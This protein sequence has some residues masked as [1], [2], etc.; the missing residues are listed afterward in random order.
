MNFPQIIQKNLQIPISEDNMQEIPNLAEQWKKIPNTPSL[1]K[2]EN[3]NYIYVESQES[4]NEF[5]TRI[6]QN[7]TCLG[8][9]IFY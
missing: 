6:L 7:E 4:F 5:L 8:I 3:N 2:Y 9:F 1:N